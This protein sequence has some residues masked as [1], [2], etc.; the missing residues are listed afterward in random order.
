M[1]KVEVLIPAIQQENLILIIC[2]DKGSVTG[3]TNESISDKSQCFLC[4]R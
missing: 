1:S 3:R 4:D 2:K